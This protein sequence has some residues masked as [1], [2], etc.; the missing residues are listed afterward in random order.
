MRR[1]SQVVTALITLIVATLAWIQGADAQIQGQWS[2]P[3]QLSHAWAKASEGYP[4]TDQ[5]GNVHLFWTET[6][7]ESSQKL[8]QHA[9]YDG[10]TWSRPVDIYVSGQNSNIGLSPFI[11]THGT[12]HLLWSEGSSGPAYYT[13]A[14]SHAELSAKS[15]LRPIRINIPAKEVRLQ[16]D[17]K[18]VLHVIY[19]NLSKEDPGL[20]YTH[21]NDDANT[22]SRPLRLDPDMPENYAPSS[23]QFSLDEKGGLHAVW[24]YISLEQAGGD[25]VRYAHS[26]DGGVNWSTPTTIDQ[27]QPGNEDYKLSAAYPIMAVHGETVHVIWAAGSMHY[28]NHRYSPDSGHTWSTPTRIFG[29]LSGQ[30]FEGF[31]KD[32]LGRI[33]WFGQIRYPQ[34]IYHAYWD[35][36]HW[37]SPELVYMISKD[38]Q[39]PIGDR[40]HA[41]HT[42]PVV[43]AGNQ[44]VLTFANSPPEEFR[45]LYVVQRTLDDVPPVAP[46]ATPTSTVTPSPAPTKTPPA[47]TPTPRPRP[48]ESLSPEP[49]VSS[50]VELLEPTQIIWVGMISPLVLIGATVVVQTY[51]RRRR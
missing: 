33:H 23:L 31:A 45:A 48:T 4:V 36:D 19:S 8:I 49:D 47:P 20:Y 42:H 17:K 5:Y 7:P 13:Y 11:D 10:H 34:G 9:R 24:F 38:S 14:P 16:V 28:R 1:K 18:G 21:S 46:R 15:W 3:Q 35:Q 37:T 27:I 43:R 50:T 12:I 40:I 26:L 2:A 6:I 29:E 22:W 25:W 51:R 41:H 30:A 44:L 39:D 32:A